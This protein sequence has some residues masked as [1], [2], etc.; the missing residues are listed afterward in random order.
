MFDRLHH[1]R[2]HT[3]LSRFNTDYLLQTGCY[4]AGGTA[5]VL[6]L[7]EYRES[8][9][10]DFLCSSHEGYRALRNTIS[11]ASLGQILNQPVELMREVRADRYGIR[12][13]AVIDGEPIKLEI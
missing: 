10:V 5:I 6:S 13:I 8:L 3:L 4:F 7:N 11:N 2:I 1:R 12:T 9:D